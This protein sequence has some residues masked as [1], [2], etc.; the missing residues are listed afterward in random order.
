MIAPWGTPALPGAGMIIYPAQN[1][2]SL[3]VGALFFDRPFPD[4]LGLNS[5]VVPLG[6]AIPPVPPMHPQSQY[7]PGMVPAS[8]YASH[9]QSVS[10]HRSDPNSPVD[11]TVAHAGHR[12]DQYQQYL[13]TYPPAGS[14]PSSTGSQAAQWTGEIHYNSSG[15]Y[16]TQQNPGQ[17]P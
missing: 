5:P 13:M 9:E 11:M 2:S 12:Q 15:G 8:P 6:P 3:L 14:P 1:S 10:P 4:F 7:T 16:T 17:Y